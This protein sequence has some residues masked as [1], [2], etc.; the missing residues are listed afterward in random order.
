MVDETSSSG[1]L[2]FVVHTSNANETEALAIGFRLKKLRE[3]FGFSQRELAKRAG[4][5]NSNIS[6]I[7][8]GQVSPS[9]HSLSLILAVFPISFSDFFHF[10]LNLRC[11]F[12]IDLSSKK[13]EEIISGV[14]FQHFSLNC[15]QQLDARI[16]SYA[17][18]TAS[19]FVSCSV[20]VS[21]VVLSGELQLRLGSGVEIMKRGDGFYVPA[22][23]PFQLNN[24]TTYDAC[25]FHCSLSSNHAVIKSF[26]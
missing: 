15:A 2:P 21:G 16:E 5:T 20:D 23:Q 9:V 7:E 12:K 8:Q 19:N 14:S 1:L 17:P 18:A 6:L 24:L 26:V 10:D 25:V 22:G 4:V 13:E 3:S 11:A